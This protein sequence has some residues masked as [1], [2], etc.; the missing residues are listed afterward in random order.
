MVRFLHAKGNPSTEIHKELV[1][2]IAGTLEVKYA[3][4]RVINID[5]TQGSSH[6]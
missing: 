6:P 2:L 4:F 1:P 3:H 5:H